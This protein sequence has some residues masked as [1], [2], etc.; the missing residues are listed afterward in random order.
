MI[1]RANSAARLGFR[2]LLFI[3]SC[4]LASEAV[5]ECCSNYNEFAAQCRSQGGIPSPNPAQC[6]PRSDGGGGTGSYASGSV[7]AALSSAAGQLGTAIGT[8]LG[9]ALF[10][11]QRDARA[12]ALSRQYEAQLAARL[13][14][15]EQEARI[16]R[17]REDLEAL[18]R[19]NQALLASL[20]GKIGHTDLAMRHVETQQLKLKSTQDIFGSGARP[21]GTTNID[22]VVVDPT[23]PPI[24]PPTPLSAEQL[25]AI[26]QADTAFVKARNSDA[27]TTALVDERKRKAELAMRLRTEAEKHVEEVR[28]KPPAP[29]S[30][31]MASPSVDDALAEAQRL[32]AEATDIEGRAKSELED[33]Q[34]QAEV[35][36]REFAQADAARKQ[37]I[38]AGNAPNVQASSTPK[39]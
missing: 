34:K 33:A 13:V 27:E 32:L 19:R 15:E 29:P 26:E 21:A 28:A 14:R 22:V 31:G 25:A 5:A 37:A 23:P 18:T 8:W 4:L 30:A 35:A 20:Q 10:G 3:G 16:R 1:R 39:P 2:V 38:G 24:A 17:A 7:D 36:S 6:N 11:Q 9:Q 12:D